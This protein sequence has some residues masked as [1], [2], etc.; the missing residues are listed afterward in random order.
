[1]EVDSRNVHGYVLGEHGDTEV[2][3]LSLTNIAGI[4]IEEY[5]QDCQGL[6]MEGIANDV[7][8][9]AYHII[10][11]KGATYYAVAL[12]VARI[13]EAIVRDENSILTVSSFIEGENGF[14]NVCFSLPSVIGIEGRKRVLNINLSD[15]ENQQL[16]KSAEALKNVIRQINF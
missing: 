16:T 14:N 10:E 8:N 2:A 7:K 1:M 6:Q 13:V 15:H 12:G 4:P 11:R 3:A 5:T 9:A